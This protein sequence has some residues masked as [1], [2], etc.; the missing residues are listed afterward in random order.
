MVNKR[1]LSPTEYFELDPEVREM[2]MIYDAYIEP[3][4][5][6]MEMLRHAYSCYFATIANP[7][8][9]ADARKQIKVKD[10]DFLNVQD[11]DSTMEKNRKRMEEKKAQEIENRTKLFEK[12]K[13]DALKGNNNNGK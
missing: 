4:G 8:L 10:F 9:T 3:S 13:K 6:Q 1:G 12:M 11:N 5:A 7:N 2:L